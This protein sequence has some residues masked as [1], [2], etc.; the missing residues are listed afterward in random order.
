M[1]KQSYCRHK[2]CYEIVSGKAYCDKHKPIKSN[3]NYKRPDRHRFYNSQKWRKLRKLYAQNHPLC[4]RCW[5]KGIVKPVDIV[6]HKISIED[7]YSKRL[8]MDNLESLCIACHNT[9]H[10]SEGE[11]GINVLEKY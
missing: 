5:S 3:D 2:G 4:E 8:D 6:H 9:E 11:K 10:F 1:A 7:D